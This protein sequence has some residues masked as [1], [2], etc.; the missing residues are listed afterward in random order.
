MEAPAHLCI[1]P[2]GGQPGVREGHEGT[3]RIETAGIVYVSDGS[4]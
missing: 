2:D 3:Y 1:T 4:R